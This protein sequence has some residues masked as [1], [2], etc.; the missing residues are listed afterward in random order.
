MKTNLSESEKNRI[1]K[2]IEEAFNT[3]IIGCESFDMELAFKVFNNSPDFYMVGPDCSICDY[4]TYIENNKN[5]FKEC[6]DFKLTTLNK[7]IKYLG[8]D[9]V[10]F[11]WVYKAEATLKTGG[12]DI[13]EKAA[14]SFLFKKINDEW[15]VIY[16]HEAA[17]PPK[18]IPEIKE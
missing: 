14:A 2:E 9:M 4:Q 12:K 7:K 15:K 8:S 11:T 13:F 16:Y 1:K 3:I 5:Y 18:K 10:F 6:S 17:L